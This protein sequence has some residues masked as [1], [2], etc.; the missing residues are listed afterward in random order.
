MPYSSELPERT[1]LRPSE[2]AS[3]FNVSPKTIYLWHEMGR[4]EGIK[5]RTTLRI[6][7]AS[8]KNLLSKRI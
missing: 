8:L 4:I 7:A 3:F 6:F 5:I 1:L 2:V